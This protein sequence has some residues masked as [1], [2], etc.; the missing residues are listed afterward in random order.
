MSSWAVALDDVVELGNA[1]G[2]G[3]KRKFA[4]SWATDCKVVDGLKAKMK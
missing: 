3:C 1:G 4:F 2:M